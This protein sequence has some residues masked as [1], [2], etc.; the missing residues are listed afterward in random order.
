MMKNRLLYNNGNSDEDLR[1]YLNKHYL[2]GFSSLY[3]TMQE[4]NVDFIFYIYK[5]GNVNNY[6]YLHIIIKTSRTMWKRLP[7]ER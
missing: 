1:K 7:S 2:F 4:G 5:F 3:V 6:P